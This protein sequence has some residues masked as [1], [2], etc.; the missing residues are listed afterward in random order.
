M[1]VL[2]SLR[3]RLAES[4]ESVDVSTRYTAA[5]K[6]SFVYVCE[7]S[8]TSNAWSVVERTCRLEMTRG[9]F[10]T[11]FLLVAL[12]SK[13]GSRSRTYLFMG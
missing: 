6:E 4:L 3:S 2:D 13:A 1:C 8:F 12:S 9:K 11:I 7:R 10:L 5:R